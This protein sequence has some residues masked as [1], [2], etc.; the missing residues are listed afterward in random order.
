MMAFDSQSVPPSTSSTGTLPLGFLARK[1]GLRC[2]PLPISTRM[3]ST[4]APRY[5]AAAQAFRALIVSAKYS[6]IAVSGLV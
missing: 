5:F 4:G 3:N 1:V 6:F 2:S